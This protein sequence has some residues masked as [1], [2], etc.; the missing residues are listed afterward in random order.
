MTDIEEPA[1]TPNEEPKPILPEILTLPYGGRVWFRDLEELNGRDFKDIRAAFNAGLAAGNGDSR[2]VYQIA[3][4]IL[5]TK[6]EIPYL[7]NLPLPNTKEGGNGQITD[8]LKWRD[9]RALDV[10]LGDAVLYMRQGLTDGDDDIPLRNA[11]G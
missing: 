11:A 2:T 8:M 10:A 3:A 5:V 1:V 9:C 4:S 7:P 6:W